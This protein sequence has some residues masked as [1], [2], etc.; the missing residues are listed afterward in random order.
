MALA[1]GHFVMHGYRGEHLP[2]ATW[3]SPQRI[4]LD[5]V[6]G[7]S[8]GAEVALDQDDLVNRDLQRVVVAHLTRSCSLLKTLTYP[9]WQVTNP[10]V[11]IVSHTA[12]GDVWV[13]LTRFH[14][15]IEG[16]QQPGKIVV[17]RVE[18]MRGA[19][20]P[21]PDH[22]G[23]FQVGKYSRIGRPQPESL[24]TRH[25]LGEPKAQQ[26]RVL[27]RHLAE[28]VQRDVRVPGRRPS[29]WPPLALEATDQVV[30]K[31]HDVVGQRYCQ[32][33]SLQ[34]PIAFTSRFRG[35]LGFPLA[36]AFDVD[37]ALLTHG[38]SMQDRWAWWGTIAP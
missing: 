6:V 26:L 34:R 5:D 15:E 23:P 11:W 8:T 29:H 13:K 30:D 25:D 27:W 21:E 20:Q 28:E 7:W 16:R 17:E 1:T 4:P 31:V 3:W 18:P 2:F 32:K 19:P 12:Q 36:L 14:L 33:Q 9:S 22:S 38:E 35:A 37:R 24:M 10:C